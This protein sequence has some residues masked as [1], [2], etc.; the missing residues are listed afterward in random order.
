MGATPFNLSAYFL[1]VCVCFCSLCFVRCIFVFKNGW[2]FVHVMH[3][4]DHAS[5]LNTSVQCRSLLQKVCVTPN[6]GVS[7]QQLP[8]N[9]VC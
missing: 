2:K 5:L 3:F 6:K 8:R 1:C 4:Y 7:R 9:F